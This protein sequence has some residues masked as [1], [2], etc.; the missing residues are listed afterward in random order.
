MTPQE[1]KNSIL[2]LAVQGK[3]VEQRAEEGTAEE[4]YKKI[5]AEK[6]KLTAEKKIKKEKPLPEITAEEI[7]FDIPESWKWVRLGEVLNFCMGKTPP[8]AESNWWGNDV[9]WISISDLV[10]NGYVKETKEK[11][12]KDAI[13]KIFGNRLSKKGTL[14]MSFKLTIGKVSILDIDAV[15]NEAIVS[16]Y[17]YYDKYDTIKYYLFKLLPY[18]IQFGESK[19][20]I[21]GKTLNSSSL[22][23]ILVAL[24][25]L[26]EQKRIVAKIEEL[27]PQ[28]DRYE[29]AWSKLEEFNKRFPDDMQ[30]SILQYA[31]QGKL[32]EQKAEEGTAEELY[33]KIQAEKQK[34]IAE[35]K[36]KKEKPLPEITAEEIPFDIPESWKWVR[37]GE[38]VKFENGDRS[39]KYPVDSD[40]V[41]IG[42]PFF[43]AKNMG[44]KYLLLNDVR[45]ISKNKFDELR[46]GKLQNNDFVCLLRGSVGKISIFKEDE[47][48]KTGFI[49]AQMVILRCFD[50]STV[51]FLY[52]AMKSEYYRK[53]IEEKTTGTAVRQLAAKEL[54]NILIPLPP[55]E[56]QKRIIAKIKELLPL[57]EKLKK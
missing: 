38:I 15:H 35:K 2:Q 46:S 43:G 47:K 56:E 36:I 24:P 25:P 11:V 18:L 55:L 51:D 3:L 41:N 45:Y 5:Q 37:L 28:I 14:V 49:C 13:V 53:F 26:E 8:R 34:L 4:L 39:S 54:A 48:H 9:N 52:Y 21:K 20:A 16:L 42:I 50:L 33:R 30:K 10:D 22:K 23:N 1:L 17:P 27:L 44:E 31:V 7:P 29:K 19:N 6:Q 57:C 32:V 12:S 40:Y